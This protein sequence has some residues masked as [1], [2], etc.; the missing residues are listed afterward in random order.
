MAAG[1][2]LEGDTLRLVDDGGA[3]ISLARH[4]I[5]AV[6]VYAMDTIVDGILRYVTVDYENGEYLD[7][8]ERLEGWQAFLG[9]LPSFLGFDPAELTRALA[10]SAPDQDAI[11]VFERTT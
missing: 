9:A 4:E 10:G 5:T 11:V 3:T 6:S 7:L 8:D 2:A 1:I